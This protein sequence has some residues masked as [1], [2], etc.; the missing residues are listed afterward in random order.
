MGDRSEKPAT[1]P[2][3]HAES[4]CDGVRSG[5]GFAKG[6]GANARSLSSCQSSGRWAGG[7]MCASRASWL[8]QGLRATSQMRAVGQCKLNGPDSG[9]RPAVPEKL[10]DVFQCPRDR[11]GAFLR[12][13]TFGRLENFDFA[14]AETVHASQVRDRTDKRGEQGH[15]DLCKP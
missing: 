9:V 7:G 10:F 1:M 11:G 14:E 13:L 8:R 4:V 6:M 12:R 2:R 3:F 15:E 5:E